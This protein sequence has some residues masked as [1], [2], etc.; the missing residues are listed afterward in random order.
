VS[1]TIWDRIENGRNRWDVLCHPFYRRWSAGELTLE[2]LRRYSGQY[3]HAVEAIATMS[4]A[5]AEA[6]PDRAELSRHADEERS[7][8]RLWDGFVDAVGG[9]CDADPTPETELCARVWTAD[10]GLLACLARLYAIESGQPAI[11]RTKRDGLARFYGIDGGVA[12]AYFRVHES[13]DEAHATE[14]RELIEELVPEGSGQE[15]AVVAAAESAFRA[16]WRLL[17]GV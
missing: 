13:R 8:V 4:A 3:R 7:H 16:N 9:D 11:S 17:D 1:T 15:E 14:A 5:T 2:E 6:A 10:H 12:T